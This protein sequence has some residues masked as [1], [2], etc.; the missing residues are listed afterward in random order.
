MI[1]LAD[2]DIDWAGATT[3]V[4][5]NISIHADGVDTQCPCGWR[6]LVGETPT[7]HHPHGW[8]MPYATRR[9]REHANA[10]DGGVHCILRDAH[11]FIVEE[12]AA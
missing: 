2:L 8:C 11:G 3:V 6:L 5:G 7:Y 10:H 1:A 12:W 4:H 9:A